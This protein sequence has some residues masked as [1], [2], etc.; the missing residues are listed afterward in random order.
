M[1]EWNANRGRAVKR[2]RFG[3]RFT[4]LVWAACW[5]SIVCLVGRLALKYVPSRTML[6]SLALLVSAAIAWRWEVLGGVLLVFEGLLIAA[7]AE[8][9]VTKGHLPFPSHSVRIVIFKALLVALA[10]SPLLSGIL[11]LASG[12]GTERLGTPGI[13]SGRT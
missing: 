10:L 3:A 12:Y 7:F 8:L 11:F 5:M 13:D 1:A 9:V 4:L 6:A 2:M